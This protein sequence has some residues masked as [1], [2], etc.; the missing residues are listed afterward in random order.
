MFGDHPE[1]EIRHRCQSL[2]GHPTKMK[3][4]WMEKSCLNILSREVKKLSMNNVT[5]FESDPQFCFSVKLL[6]VLAREFED[7]ISHPI[8]FK[9]M[10]LLLFTSPV[11]KLDTE[12]SFKNVVLKT[13][14][15][16][17][18][19]STSN[20]NHPSKIIQNM[21]N[22]LDQF[23][24]VSGSINFL[25]YWIFKYSAAFWRVYLDMSLPFSWYYVWET[26]ILKLLKRILFLYF[27]Q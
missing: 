12:S 6:T 26:F 25:S 1:H 3:R 4:I 13:F 22:A 7:L 10:L 5:Q 8:A 24:M 16:R 14:S 15:R 11:Q 20:G 19:V 23:R 18:D 9:T 27:G 2:M 17:L 21:L